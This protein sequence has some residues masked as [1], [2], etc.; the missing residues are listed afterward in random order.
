MIGSENISN[1]ELTTA[2]STIITSLP[3]TTTTAT[4]STFQEKYFNTLRTNFT[5]DCT[6]VHTGSQTLTILIGVRLGS[7]YLKS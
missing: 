7:T 5:A 6:Y 4:A 1:L 3:S 2:T